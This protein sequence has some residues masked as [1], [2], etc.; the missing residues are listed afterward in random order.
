MNFENREE[1]NKWRVK[2]L[3][4]LIGYLASRYDHN[5]R[6]YTDFTVKIKDV[7]YLLENFMDVLEDSN[8]YTSVDIG[9]IGS[10]DIST[11]NFKIEIPYYSMLEIKTKNYDSKNHFKIHIDMDKVKKITFN[12]NCET[13]FT[14]NFKHEI[15]KYGYTLS[16]RND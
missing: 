11:D 5:E 6:S 8:L 14:I 15:F 16:F 7:R 4:E 1:R 3:N 9:N 2:R 13:I 10:S 12:V